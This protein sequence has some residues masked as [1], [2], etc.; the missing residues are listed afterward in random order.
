MPPV[1]SFAVTAATRVHLTTRRVKTADQN[2]SDTSAHSDLI[3]S[4][5]TEE[6][7]AIDDTLEAKVIVDTREVHEDIIEAMVEGT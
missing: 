5:I 4:L 3:L 1:S 6:V 7:E 2:E